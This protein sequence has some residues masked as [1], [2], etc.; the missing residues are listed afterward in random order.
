MFAALQHSNKTF[1]TYEHVISAYSYQVKWSK[2]L[3]LLPDIYT[4]TVSD[5]MLE[6]A[7]AGLLVYLAK[8]I[9]LPG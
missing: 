6:K 5:H 1:L 4:H 9:E 7:K 8:R 3:D 2:F